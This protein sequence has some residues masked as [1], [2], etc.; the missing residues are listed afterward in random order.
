MTALRKR[1]LRAEVQHEGATTVV[2]VTTVEGARIELREGESV[3]HLQH[4]TALG[5]SG[6]ITEALREQL[7]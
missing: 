1:G 3:I 7:L 4:G 6:L 2:K 5:V